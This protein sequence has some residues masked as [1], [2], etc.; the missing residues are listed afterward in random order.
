MVNK[1]SNNVMMQNTAGFQADCLAT[2]IGS[3]PLTDHDQAIDLILENVPE[4]PCWAQLPAHKE[5]G[6]VMQ[7][8]S[9]LPGLCNESGNFFVNTES[10]NFD[11]ELLQFFEEYMAVDEGETGLDGSRFNLT[12]E[13]A[14][15]FFM[16]WDR[17]QRLSTPPVAVKGQIT[18]P[19]TFCTGIV[20]HNKQAIFYNPQIRDAAVKLLAMKAKWQVQQLSQLKRPV[21]IFFDEPGLAG[22]GSSGF[23]SISNDEISQC[24]EEVLDAVHSEGGLAGVHVCANTDWSVVLGSSV[25]IVNFDA[26]GYFD[27]FVLY[28]EKIKNYLDSGNILAW[29]IVPTL[30]PEELERETSRS[31]LGQWEEKAHQIEALGIDKQKLL[32]QSLIT[33]SCGTGSLSVDLARK[34]IELTREVSQELRNQY[35]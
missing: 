27:R 19:F 7:F 1:N 11:D 28:P 34:A 21:I 14:N 5:E 18:G 31:L 22:V 23:T 30:N 3:M 10:S 6:M 26:Y 9:G 25:D 32:K 29:G 16:L 24:F 33:P 8:A 4:I 17:L 20:D 15:G 2:F 12:K 13:T 35:L